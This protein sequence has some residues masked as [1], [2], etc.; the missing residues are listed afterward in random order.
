MTDFHCC[1]LPLTAAEDLTQQADTSIQEA[2]VQTVSGVRITTDVSHPP[3][4]QPSHISLQ[5]P[6]F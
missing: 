3:S 6:A 5:S 4:V 1:K 2:G